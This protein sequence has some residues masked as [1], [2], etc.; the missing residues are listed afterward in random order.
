[1]GFGLLSSVVPAQA[2]VSTSL[3]AVV[4]PNG[5]TSLTV[6]G[7]DTTTTAALVRLDVTNDESSTSLGLRASETITASVTAVPSA[8]TAKTLASNGGSLADTGTS[9]GAG[10]SDF[11]MIE[12]R[13]QTA[14]VPAATTATTTSSNTDWSRMAGMNL[15][16]TYMDTATQGGIA[17]SSRAADGR[18]GMGNSNFVNMDTFHQNTSV[19]YTTSYYVTIRPRANSNVIDQG[20]YTFQ[21]QLVDANGVVRGTKTVKIDFVSAASKSDAVL[22]LTP[23]GTF[24]VGAALESYDS[25]TANSYASA[26]LRNRDAGLVRDFTGAAP[27]I[28]STVQLSTTAAPGFIDTITVVNNDSGTYGLDYGTNSATSPG[29]G[30][31]QAQDGIYGLTWA[32]GVAPVAATSAT[33]GAVRSYRWQIGYGNATLLTPALTV[34]AASGSGTASANYTDV[35]VTAA[36]MSA[37]DQ[38]K[39][40]DTDASDVWTVPTT[41]KTATVKFWIQTSSDTATPAA[42][43][44]VTPTW[45]GTFGTASVS[46]ATSTTGTVY[47]TDALG[48]ISVTVTNDAPVAG[49]SVALVLSGGS[50]FGAGTYTATINWAKPVATSIDVADPITGVYVKTGST[51]VTTVI[52]KDQFGNPVAGES[53]SVSLSSTSA[54]YSATTTIAPITTGAA[55]TATYSLVGGATTATLDA[56][57]FTSVTSGA[58]APMTYNYV[59]TVPAVATMVAYHGYSHATAGTT[60]T[61]A[62]GIYQSGTTTELVLRSNR[63]LS[64]S[65]TSFADSTADDMINLRFYGL[66]TGSVAATG[67]VVTVTAGDGGHILDASGLPV[68]TRNFLVLSTGYTQGIQ[69]LATKTGAITFTAT[70]G[71]VTATAAMWVAN[72][73]ADARNVKITSAATGTANGAGIPVTVTVTDRYGNPVSGVNLNVV[74][75]GAGSFMGGSINQSFLTDSS[76]LYTFLATSNLSD[77]GVAKFTATSGNSGTSMG[78]SAG[79]VGATVVDATLAAGNSSASASITFAAGASASD[80]AQTAT[81]AAAEATDAANA[82]TDA[83]NAAAEAADAA[84]A[85]AQDA[86]DAVAALSAQVATLISGLKAQLTALTNLV[87][88]IQKKVKA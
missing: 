24:L 37:A 66:A 78:D 52:V 13:G 70:S 67:A 68:K 41:T 45:S 72:A 54:N 73:T 58:T 42:A 3:N 49:A 82:A 56:I 47:T 30:S 55:G 19:Q 8:V 51:N 77:G 16:S 84:T 87:I 63:D 76:G 4:G 65:L 5:A 23:T 31:L 34:Y 80:V 86:A 81:D 32:A 26:T 60:L 57:T 1:L 10:Y 11:V 21:F 2:N 20:A 29:N 9:P 85:A 28:L 25:A 17:F 69:V 79:Y 48:N 62:T 64:R 83:A 33:A 44:T 6:V 46:P 39:N 7:G 61:P 14:G 38:L 59:T 36:G 75:S 88:K 74:A 27:A 71:T 43:I 35:L 50:A 22:T 15:P 40:T 12:T 53:V 18:V